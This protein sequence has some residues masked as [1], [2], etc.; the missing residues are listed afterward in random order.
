MMHPSAL[1]DT[2]AT[3]F[4]KLRHAVFIKKFYLAGGTALALRYGHR[5]SVDLDFFSAHKFSTELLIKAL[6]KLGKFKLINEEAGTVDGILDGV[7]VSFF[8]YPYKLL[9]KTEMFAGIAIA[10]VADIACMKIN[11]IAGRNARKDF[12]D[13]YFILD[14]ASWQIEDVL[15]LCDKKFGAAQRDCYHLLRAMVFFEEADAQPEV[16]TTPPVRWTVIKK[17]F[18]KEVERMSKL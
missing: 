11:A 6:S 17:F 16:K 14:H 13:L 3:V 4:Q 18:V 9:N 2:T 7:K 1:N 12:I 8:A 15:H 5:E 10:D